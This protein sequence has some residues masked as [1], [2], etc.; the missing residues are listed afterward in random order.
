M[1]RESRNIRTQRVGA[2]ARAFRFPL[3]GPLSLLLTCTPL[4]FEAEH[5]TDRSPNPNAEWAPINRSMCS[6][7]S[8]GKHQTDPI[9]GMSSKAAESGQ[10]SSGL[11]NLGE[12]KNETSDK[13]DPPADDDEGPGIEPNRPETETPVGGQRI[14]PE[15][16]GAPG[17]NHGTAVDWGTMQKYFL[18]QGASPHPFPGLS[19]G[20]FQ[21]NITPFGGVSSTHRQ[22]SRQSSTT[23]PSPQY[24]HSIPCLGVGRHEDG[25]NSRRRRHSRWKTRCQHYRL[26]QHQE[27]CR[28]RV[29]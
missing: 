17:R 28:Q 1:K 2:P 10:G 8:H 26:Q 18:P 24:H 11:R 19:T 23:A 25:R 6:D 21:S 22:S 20:G 9:Q 27:I 5:R 4:R 3:P 16:P 29:G 12:K 7:V 15:N 14:P 13:V